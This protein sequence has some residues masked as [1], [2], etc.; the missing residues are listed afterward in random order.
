MANRL[1]PPIGRLSQAMIVLGICAVLVGALLNVRDL[2]FLQSVEGFLLD[3]RFMQ[4]GPVDVDKNIELVVMQGAESPSASTAAKIASVIDLL[5]ADG[6]GVIA[7]APSLLVNLTAVDTTTLATSLSQ[8]KSPLVGYIFW[9]GDPGLSTAPSLSIPPVIQ[10]NSYLNYRFPDGGTGR[11]ATPIGIKPVSE[12]L[13]NVATPGHFVIT[14]DAAP[15]RRHAYPVVGYDGKYYPSLA[16]EAALLTSELDL[17]AVSITFGQKLEFASSYI[18]TD[19][20]TRIAVNYRGPAGGYSTRSLDDIL[21]GKVP[22]GTYKGK[23]VLLGATADIGESF[24]SPF[25]GEM[26]DVEFLATIVDN[27]WRADPLDHS[28]Q[29]VILDIIIIALIGVFFALLATMRNA[30]VVLVM[31]ILAGGLVGVVN[32]Q[33]FA[34]LN[35]WLS[36][37]FPLAALFLC[38]VYLAAAKLVSNRRARELAEAERVETSKYATPWIAERVAKARMLEEKSKDKEQSEQD[39]ES[40]EEELEPILDNPEL[41]DTS[42][43]SVIVD[44]PLVLEKKKELDEGGEKEAPTLSQP[45]EI[46]PEDPVEAPEPVPT[47]EELEAVLLLTPEESE[48][49]A[50]LILPIVEIEPEIMTD[51]IVALEPEPETEEELVVESV[52]EIVPELIE[53][54][55]IAEPPDRTLDDENTPISQYF[56]VAV[57]YVDLRAFNNSAKELG[58]TLTAPFLHGVHDLI[59]QE[60]LKNQGFVETFKDDG[61]M[62]IFGLP[63]DSPLDTSHALIAA[64]KIGRGLSDYMR[65]HNFPRDGSLIFNIGLHIGPVFV[66]GEEKDGSIALKLSG[67]TMTIASRLQDVMDSQSSAIIASAGLI[68]DVRAAGGREDLLDN[69]VERPLDAGYESDASLSVWSLEIAAL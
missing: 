62:A 5:V 36:L 37:S 19:V 14:K 65:D 48:K 35:L 66:E 9:E 13:L 38:T 17:S 23:L 22:T 64:R 46:E 29:V 56:P 2:P 39:T 27:L 31:A 3:L 45:V 7:I 10:R 53:T 55:L 32:F 50:E 40:S 42:S 59:E 21:D 43:I 34:L 60:T 15:V 44:E 28:Q 8:V 68:E 25:G 24:T 41:P 58:P 16:V 69:F 33:A 11:V 51:P 52:P 1:R 54:D 20:L 4:R 30:T 26:L 57:L 6:A 67:D 49:E 63:E 61:V 47:Q 12:A 18:P